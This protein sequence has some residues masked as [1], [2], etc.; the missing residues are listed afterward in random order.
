MTVFFVTVVPLFQQCRSRNTFC[1]FSSALLSLYVCVWGGGGLLLRN[2]SN[3]VPRTIEHNIFVHICV[4]EASGDAREFNFL[5]QRFSVLIRRRFNAI[6]ISE[7]F[8]S[9]DIPDL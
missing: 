3:T 7:T 9:D 5:W 1:V 2:N 6:L 4:S 8:R